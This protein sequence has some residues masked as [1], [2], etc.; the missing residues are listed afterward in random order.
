VG[1]IFLHERG[2]G[3]WRMKKRIFLFE[4]IIKSNICNYMFI[5]FD[6]IRFYLLTPFTTYALLSSDVAWSRL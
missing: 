3:F 4:N 2:D 6:F 5:M 1:P